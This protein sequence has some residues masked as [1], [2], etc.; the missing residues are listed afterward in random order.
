MSFALYMLL[1]SRNNSKAIHGQGAYFRVPRLMQMLFGDN[2][3]TLHHFLLRLSSLL[4]LS[5]CLSPEL[6]DSP[7]KENVMFTRKITDQRCATK[8]TV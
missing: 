2:R 4:P 5:P 8:K 7:Q 3:M 1:A 6:E